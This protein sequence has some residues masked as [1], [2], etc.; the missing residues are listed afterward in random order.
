MPVIKPLAA[1]NDQ[2]KQY[3]QPSRKGK[4]AWRRNIDLTEI[5]D[6]L[7]ELN[8]QVIAG[9]VA[10]EKKSEDI[11]TVDVSRDKT[12]AKKIPQHL[13]KGLRADEIIAQRSAVP[14]V[15]QRKRPGDKTTDGILPV[16]RQR[17]NYVTQKELARLRKVADG[18]QESTVEIVDAT[19]DMWADTTEPADDAEDEDAFLPKQQKVK[20]PKTLSR[21]PVSLASNGKPIPAVQKPKGGASYN[22]VFDDYKNRLV[23]EG[24]KAVAAERK[25]L[26]E[27]E[28]DR[29]KQEAA[30]RS[31]A[32]ADAAEARADLSE[33]DEDSAWEGIESGGEELSVKAKRPQRKTPAQR[34]KV[35]RRKEEERRTKHEAQMK[36]KD[37]QEKRIKQIAKEVAER[38]RQLALEKV[39]MSDDSMEGNDE[40]LR[41]KQLGKFRLPE[42]DLE[43]VLPDELQDSLRLLKPEGNLL[44]DRYRSIL[45]RGKVEARRHIPFRKQKKTK[46]TEKWSHKDFTLD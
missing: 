11:F 39:E 4:G 14:A 44:R 20:A 34:N 38:E 29:L 12:I 41:R 15:S 40:E 22:P 5:V 43:L 10:A 25:R 36:R 46:L 2:P 33:W 42:K 8:K 35:K 17:T 32:E 6:G 23:E 21:K 18:Q 13:K 16:K 27:E 30:A 24:D 9:G 37:E 45:V 31:A 3:K 28:A 19:Y 7:E 1:A 26:E